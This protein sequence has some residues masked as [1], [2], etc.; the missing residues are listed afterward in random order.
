MG[1]CHAKPKQNKRSRKVSPDVVYGPLNEIETAFNDLRSSLNVKAKIGIY[2]KLILALKR[3]CLNQQRTHQ[4]IGETYKK[5]GR[6]YLELGKLYSYAENLH[7]AQDKFEKAA[8]YGNAEAKKHLAFYKSAIEAGLVAGEKETDVN[9]RRTANPTHNNN[10]DP[11]P[12]SPIIFS[13]GSTSV[14]SKED[15]EHRT[16][17]TI[18][19]EASQLNSLEGIKLKFSGSA[20]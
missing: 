18:N 7:M 2:S 6:A 11:Y 1:Q 16:E 14:D 4:D 9:A 5:L 19:F 8:S 12:F 20:I 15:R 10:A 3:K 17:G 13:R